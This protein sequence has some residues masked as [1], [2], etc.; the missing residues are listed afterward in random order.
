M[1]LQSYD[2]FYIQDSSNKEKSLRPANCGG[3]H[4]ANHICIENKKWIPGNI[5]LLCEE[6]IWIKGFVIECGHSYH[7]QCLYNFLSYCWDRNLKGCCPT[8]RGKISTT[9]HM[10]LQ[11]LLVPKGSED[12]DLFMN[13]IP[14][15]RVDLNPFLQIV[16]D[17]PYLELVN[18]PMPSEAY[19]DWKNQ[20][21]K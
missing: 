2:D 18:F 10:Q 17:G 11:H 16:G 6:S 5:C 1:N 7:K 20:T 13:P 12:A 3:V 21:Y 4:F 19:W 14:I 9:V 8:C 15:G